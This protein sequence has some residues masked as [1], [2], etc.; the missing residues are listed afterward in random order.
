MKDPFT[1]NVIII[2]AALA[3][4]VLLTLAAFILS[5]TFR[6]FFLFK[7]ISGNCTEIYVQLS[8]SQSLIN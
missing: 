2:G 1:I 7:E 4:L 6:L 8:N 5:G 3:I